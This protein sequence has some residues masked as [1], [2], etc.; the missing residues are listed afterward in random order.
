MWSFWRIFAT[1]YLAIDFTG[2]LIVTIKYRRHGI[3]LFLPWLVACF[4]ELGVLLYVIGVL[5]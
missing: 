2:S 3:G 1:V 5:R 4:L